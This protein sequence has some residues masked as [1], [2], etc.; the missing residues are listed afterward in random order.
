MTVVA[1]SKSPEGPWENSPYNPLVH[2]YSHDE[3]WWHQGHGTIFEAADG[4][5]WT[6]Y[7]ARLNN[8]TELGRST[9]LLPVEWTGDDWPVV[10]N[11][12]QAAS[13][14]PM[15]AGEKVQGGLPLS[16]NFESEKPGMQWNVNHDMKQSLT[17]GNGKLTMKARGSSV[18]DAA[19]ITVGAVNKSFEVSVEV[20]CA[21]PKTIAGLTLGTDGIQTNGIS[22]T[23]SDAPDWRMNGA[24]IR[25]KE[26]GKVYMKIKNFRKDLSFFISDDGINWQS[27]GK[28]LRVH[29]SFEIRLFA[30]GSGEAIFKN[31]EYKGLE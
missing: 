22:S 7:H 24:T 2:T 5:W 11:G 31:F 23:F 29:G 9:L 12:Y 3:K 17:F 18:R 19:C 8:F 26:E 6:V 13:L 21:D 30:A 28:G 27:F 1:R 20:N 16:D 14:I 15:P 25:A 4:T 10:K